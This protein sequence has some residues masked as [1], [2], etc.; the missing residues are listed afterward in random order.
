MSRFVHPASVVL[1]I[2]EGDSLTVKARLNTGE[3]R[4]MFARMYRTPENG[5]PAAAQLDPM[6]VS[7]ARVTAYLL[8][9]TLTNDDGHLVE[10]R[11]RPVAEVEDALNAL[12][13]DDFVEIRQAIDGHIARLEHARAEEKKTRRGAPT[14]SATGTSLDDA[15]GATNGSPSSTPTSTP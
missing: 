3:Q 13:P 8:D 15:T 6:A 1:S 9:W 12:D 5:S 11:D 14:S 7:M 2:S 4:A 10:I